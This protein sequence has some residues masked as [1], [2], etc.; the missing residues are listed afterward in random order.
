[1]INYVRNNLITVHVPVHL[2]CHRVLGQVIYADLG[3][4]NRDD[5]RVPKFEVHSILSE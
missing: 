5:D 3:L 4:T 1:M 2:I